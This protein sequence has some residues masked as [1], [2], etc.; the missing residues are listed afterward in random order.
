M[1]SAIGIWKSLG[2][3]FLAFL[4]R[5]GVFVIRFFAIFILPISVNTLCSLEGYRLGTQ[6]YSSEIAAFP[7]AH[8]TH[9]KAPT[10]DWVPD[11]NV[12]FAEGR[13][14]SRISESIDLPE[15]RCCELKQMSIGI[16]KIDA[17]SAARPTG[18]SFDLDVTLT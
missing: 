12:E 5:F 15:T 10:L 8:P 11:G 9:H 3:F 14:F 6:G 17:A 18:P 2:G 7:G 13:F 4:R 1:V 16:S